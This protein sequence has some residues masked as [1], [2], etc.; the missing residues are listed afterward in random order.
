VCYSYL[1]SIGTLFAFVLVCVGIN[2]MR[3]TLPDAPRKF[4]TP[5]VPWVPLMGIV[6]CLIMMSSLPRESWER[7]VIWMAI[8]I[9]VYF[10]Y[11]R[12]HSKVGFS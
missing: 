4:K 8:G 10:G 3:K 7:L 5:L 2:I 11:G 9:A 12:K 6:V 1:V